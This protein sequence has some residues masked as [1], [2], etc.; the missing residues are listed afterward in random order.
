V[1]YAD[2]SALAKLVLLEPESPAMQALVS[3]GEHVVT[4]VVGVVEL[5]RLAAR[6]GAEASRAATRVV[7]R[8]DRLLL[9]PFAVALAGQL[10]PPEVRTLDALHI[11]SAAELADLRVLATYDRRM[12]E[13]ARSYGLPVMSP[14]R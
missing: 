2:A 4:N 8:V 14:G 10:P 7:G 12:A 13:A 9:T 3:S 6:A 5:Q 11:A 1:I